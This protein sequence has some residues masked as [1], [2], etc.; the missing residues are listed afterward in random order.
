M[1][2]TLVP[3]MAINTTMKL[4]S[5]A[6]TIRSLNLHFESVTIED[7]VATVQAGSVA[8]YFFDRSDDFQSGCTDDP[9][10][11]ATDP[12]YQ[13][14]PVFLFDVLA[15]TFQE[16][17]A[18]FELRGL[19]WANMTS[20]AR[21]S[22]SKNSTD[23]DL[24]DAIVSILAPLEDGHVTFDA[25]EY[26]FS[27]ESKPAAVIL[28]L[29]EEFQAQE[30]IPDWDDYLTSQI[31]TWLI[32]LGQYMDDEDGLQFTN[33]DEVSWGTA[34]NGTIGYLNVFSYG[35]RGHRRLLARCSSRNDRPS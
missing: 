17:Y 18:F 9:T 27:F 2:S 12:Q 14:D 29:L 7:T 33:L 32:T 4:P 24:M 5:L 19:D 15:Q 34:S 35:T 25:E 20:E 21:Q 6:S 23:E 8:D 11:M 16:H 3:K 10:M 13:R 31:T 1:S 28:Q 26:D 22:L 30:A